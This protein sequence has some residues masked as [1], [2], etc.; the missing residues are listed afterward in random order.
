MEVVKR[1]G[2]RETF[3]PEKITVSAVKAG[4]SYDT[5][6][7]IA[8]SAQSEFESIAE[9]A[10]IRDYVL[11]ELRSRGEKSAAQSWERYDQEKKG[12]K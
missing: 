1:S 9:T 4:A 11:T 10:Q 8:G 5:A 7:S 12:R 2:E 3:M 6:R